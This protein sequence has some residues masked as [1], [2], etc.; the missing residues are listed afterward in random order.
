[1]CPRKRKLAGEDGLRKEIQG[2]M[3][4]DVARILASSCSGIYL[5][6]NC[7]YTMTE[8]SSKID[9]VLHPAE[10]LTF[11]RCENFKPKDNKCQTL[12][13]LY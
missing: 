9:A 3:L 5:A 2:D 6:P 1:M 7:A 12:W 4:Q 8:G 13:G 10:M 11:Q